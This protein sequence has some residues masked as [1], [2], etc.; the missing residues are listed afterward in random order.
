MVLVVDDRSPAPQAQM[1]EVAAGELDCAYVLQQDGEGHSAAFNV[2]LAAAAEHG[3]DALPRR[4]RAAS[5]SPRGWLD[6]LRARTGTDGEPAAVAGGAVLEA[7]R[8]DPPGRLLL[9]A[10]PPRLERAP[11]PRPAGAARRRTTRCCARSAPSC[12]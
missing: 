7:D 4:A 5:S 12:S 10:L 11:A 6:R 8:H 3:M 2:G 1:I 9:L